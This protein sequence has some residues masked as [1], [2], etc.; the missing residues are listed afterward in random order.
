MPSKDSPVFWLILAWTVLLLICGGGWFLFHGSV[1]FGNLVSN[2]MSG[3][4]SH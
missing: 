3:V 1:S 4:F 2:F